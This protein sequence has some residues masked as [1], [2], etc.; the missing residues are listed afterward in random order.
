MNDNHGVCLHT[1][2]YFSLARHRDTLETHTNT[3]TKVSIINDGFG[4]QAMKMAMFKYFCIV[5]VVM[6]CI[7]YRSCC[8]LSKDIICV[9]TVGYFANNKKAAQ[10]AVFVT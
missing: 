5:L 3:H 9:G 2:L 6:I 8:H 10:L 1:I 4:F 7:F